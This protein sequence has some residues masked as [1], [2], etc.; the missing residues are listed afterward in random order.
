[1]NR[2]KALNEDWGVEEAVD[3][4]IVRMFRK[5]RVNIRST[6][7]TRCNAKPAIPKFTFLVWYQRIFEDLPTILRTYLIIHGQ[8]V[9]LLSSGGCFFKGKT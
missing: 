6:K 1:M 8:S 5:I 7:I 4:G 9:R 2:M 3:N